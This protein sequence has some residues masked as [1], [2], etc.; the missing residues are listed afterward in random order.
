MTV[1]SINIEKIQLTDY[2]Y[3]FFKFSGLDEE[4]FL[5]S[6]LLQSHLGRDKSNKTSTIHHEAFRWR[7]FHRSESI[8]AVTCFWP[9]QR[10]PSAGGSWTS[11]RP[12]W[13]WVR[14]PVLGGAF[15]TGWGTGPASTTPSANC[16]FSPAEQRQIHEKRVKLNT[17]AP[18]WN[19]NFVYFDCLFVFYY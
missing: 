2:Q 7:L 15:W 9:R 10:G 4:V 5:D 16:E 6:G 18:V 19:C 17:P 8:N 13:V 14:L 1:T 3:Y 11:C 12:A